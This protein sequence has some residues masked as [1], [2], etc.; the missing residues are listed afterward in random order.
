MRTKKNGKRSGTKI[1]TWQ[2]PPTITR[3]AETVIRAVSQRNLPLPTVSLL[4][5]KVPTVS[6]EWIQ[7]GIFIDLTESVLDPNNNLFTPPKWFRNI[8]ALRLL[9]CK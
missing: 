7:E 4:P 2:L 1:S 8:D 5:D 3:T 6:M 9:G